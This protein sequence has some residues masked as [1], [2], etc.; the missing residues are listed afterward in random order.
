MGRFRF[1]IGLEPLLKPPIGTYLIWGQP[2]ALFGKLAAQVFV[3]SQDARRQRQYFLGLG[4]DIAK[5]GV[6]FS[7][8][9]AGKLDMLDLVLTHRLAA[10]AGAARAF[11]GGD[12]ARRVSARGGDE[13]GDLGRAFNAMAAAR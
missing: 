13:I 9:V 3:D 6:E 10:L 5:A 11:E 1:G 8:N 2:G 12:L 4:E 7:C